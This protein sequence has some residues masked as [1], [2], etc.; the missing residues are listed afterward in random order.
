MESC[1]DV[2]FWGGGGVY[3]VVSL[4]VNASSKTVLSM[5]S[6]EMDGGE[7]APPL[8]SEVELQ[9]PPQHREVVLFSAAIKCAMYYVA[10]LETYTL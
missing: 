5:L 2:L 8:S 6:V 9:L 10:C 3:F 7:R 1:E 4:R